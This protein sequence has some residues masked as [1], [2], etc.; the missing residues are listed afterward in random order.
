MK[1][2]FIG[3]EFAE[4]LL[5]KVCVN[6][7]FLFSIHVN[8]CHTYYTN[9]LSIQERKFSENYRQEVFLK[10]LDFGPGTRVAIKCLSFFS[11]L[12]N[13]FLAEMVRTSKTFVSVFT[14]NCS[15]SCQILTQSKLL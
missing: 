12:L 8:A 6:F 7:L 10:Q 13:G 15:I 11:K 3:L 14:H 1:L 2:I 9:C 5:N 4:I